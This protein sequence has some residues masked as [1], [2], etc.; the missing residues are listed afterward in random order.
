M[1]NMSRA[2][3]SRT[4]SP[5][6]DADAIS[7]ELLQQRTG[8]VGSS[9]S[10]DPALTDTLLTASDSSDSLAA[11]KPESKNGPTVQARSYSSWSAV[12]SE[13]LWELSTWFIGTISL[14]VAVILLVSFNNKPL[15]RWNSR[16]SLNAIASVLSQAAMSAL[17][18]PVSSSIGQMKWIWYRRDNCFLDVDSFDKASRGPQGSL[19][20]LWKF[21]GKA[22][23]RLQLPAQDK[24]K[25][26]A[27]H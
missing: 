21:R 24:A 18:F 13:W 7:L 27:G 20:F 9:A 5:V 6:S 8:T 2:Q 23:T 19:E 10:A 3:T 11:P 14:L 12:V 15:N 16:I 17:L 1:S 26:V 25:E 22:Y 4:P